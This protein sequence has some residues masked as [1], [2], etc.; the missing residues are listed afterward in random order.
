M[1]KDIENCAEGHPDDQHDVALPAEMHAVQTGNRHQ[2]EY[3]EKKG[4]DEPGN[5]H[6]F[7]EGG[8]VA[9]VDLLRGRACSV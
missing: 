3:H 5:G 8:Y 4:K 7:Q 2:L 6:P 9:L 1:L